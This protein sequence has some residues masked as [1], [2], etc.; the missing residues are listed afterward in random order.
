MTVKNTDPKKNRTKHTF[1][2]L[3]SFAYFFVRIDPRL[4]NVIEKSMLIM[5]MTKLLFS[6]LCAAS[7]SLESLAST[8]EDNVKLKNSYDRQKK[9]K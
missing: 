3:T 9:S 8:I 4:S 6:I 1:H 7:S 2:A 5:P